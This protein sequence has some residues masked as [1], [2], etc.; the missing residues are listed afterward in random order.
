MQGRSVQTGL[1]GVKIDVRKL[2]A[3]QYILEITEV[4][5]QHRQQFIKAD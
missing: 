2:P 4:G 5:S 1:A 3:G